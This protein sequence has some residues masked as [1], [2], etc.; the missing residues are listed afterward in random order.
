MCVAHTCTCAASAD[1][2]KPGSS[3]ST[4]QEHFPWVAADE[5]N[6]L[7]YSSEFSGVNELF[8]YSADE[9]EL[10]RILSLNTTLENIQGGAFY[11]N[12]GGT[13][14]LSTDTSE[15]TIFVVDTESGD[16]LPWFDVGGDV[17]DEM[18]GIAFCADGTTM[19][20]L[21]GTLIPFMISFAIT[22]AMLTIVL[23]FG[24]LGFVQREEISAYFFGSRQYSR[25][26]EESLPPLG[27]SDSQMRKPWKRRL[28]IKV[29]ASFN[30]AALFAGLMAWGLVGEF[31]QRGK[32]ITY[33][34]TEVNVQF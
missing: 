7:L 3:G 20:A 33:N 19:L 12:Q 17:Y 28:G 5:P 15:R 34:I 26:E 4:S 18:E 30:L 16:V 6:N 2:L 21:V 8:V 13:L 25:A 11:A 31:G 9:F 32:L 1:T 24:V 10:L 14:Y 22:F 23:F 27:N 29:F